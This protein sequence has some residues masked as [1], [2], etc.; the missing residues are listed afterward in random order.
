MFIA[1]GELL[2]TN[3]LVEDPYDEGRDPFAAWL[4]R[5]DLSRSDNRWLADRRDPKPRIYL[6]TPEELRS[7]DWWR[8]ISS[9]EFERA[10]YSASGEVNVWG[11]WSEP[12]SN[13][14]FTQR[15][16]VSTALVAQERS[17]ALLRA[18]QTIGD[19]Y[20]FRI[21][22][23]GD[24]LEIEEGLYRLKGWI[25]RSD[26]EHGIDS[27]DP[28]AGD[29]R[30]PAP[31]PAEYVVELMHLSCDADRRVWVTQSASTPALTS[32]VWG[33]FSAG[34][35][36]EHSNGR[37]LHASISFLLEFLKASAMDMVVEIDIQ[38][39]PRYQSYRNRDD[40]L[41]DLPQ[42]TRIYIIKSDG[43]IR[44]F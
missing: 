25:V 36:R 44:A 19:P 21:P 34:E 7:S 32:E 18:L 41:D 40:E 9:D 22:P 15:I 2:S 27:A 16:S 23:F 5:H 11:E 10:L 26:T 37:R 14:S 24:D 30:F 31:Q 42:S 28:W 8:S 29:V 38:K 35:D 3:P 20:D 33:H 12:V 43:T 6:A 4:S 17:D 13:A 39:R 1:A